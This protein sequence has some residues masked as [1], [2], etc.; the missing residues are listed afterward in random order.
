[1]SWYIDKPR[2]L[3]DE[4]KELS[5]KIFKLKIRVDKNTK[6]IY[7]LKEELDFKVHKYNMDIGAPLI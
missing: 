2:Y 3:S 4:I 7:R 1:M 5:E 6:E